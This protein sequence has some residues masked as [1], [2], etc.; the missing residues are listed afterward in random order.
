MS[1]QIKEHDEQ[2]LRKL[3]SQANSVMGAHPEII[4]IMQEEAIKFFSGEKTAEDVAAATQSR[5]SIF[6]AEQYG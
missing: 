5:V 6:M 3:I 2:E 4:E 1:I